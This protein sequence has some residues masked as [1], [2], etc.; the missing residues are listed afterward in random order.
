MV[1]C[2][3]TNLPSVLERPRVT[4]TTSLGSTAGMGTVVKFTLSV[5]PLTFSNS[6]WAALIAWYWFW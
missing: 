2:S 6:A 3:T 1:N 5:A 4:V